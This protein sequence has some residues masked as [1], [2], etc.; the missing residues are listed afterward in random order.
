MEQSLVPWKI[1]HLAESAWMGR[2]DQRKPREKPEHPNGRWSKD[3]VHDNL[4]DG[5]AFRTLTIIDEFLR[6]CPA[7]EVDP[8]LSGH[9]VVRVLQRL[10]KTRGLPQEIG[11]DQGT[12]F[13]SKVLTKWALEEDSERSSKKW[14]GPHIN[15]ATVLFTRQAPYILIGRQIFAR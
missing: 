12:E 4:A 8:S 6:E 1:F 15:R 5:R 7:L 13:T 9:R 2:A 3:F 11:V 14:P 10:A